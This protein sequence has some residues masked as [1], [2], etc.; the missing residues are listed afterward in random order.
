MEKTED[1][2][3]ESALRIVVDDRERRAGLPEAVAALWT[4]TFVGRLPVGDVEIGSRILVERKTVADLAASMDDGRLFRQARA[5]SRACPCPLLIIE[6]EDGFDLMHVPPNA[7]RGLL[8]TL[9]VGYRI[10]ILR[11]ASVSETAVSLAQLARQEK[12][13]MER[14]RRSRRS[15][16][17]AARTALE[18]LGTIPG[19]GDEKARRLIEGLGSLKEVVVASEKELRSV[20]GVGPRTAREVRRAL[21]GPERE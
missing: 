6:G 13:R 4:P 21:D 1:V 3:A 10:P 7:L 12:K 5:I 18:V 17:T 20:P 16:K 15:G 11:T 9:L 14:L 2:Q 8:L 19:I